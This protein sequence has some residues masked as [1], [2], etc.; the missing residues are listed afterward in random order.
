MSDEQ[1]IHLIHKYRSSTLSETEELAFFSWYAEVDPGEFHR[2]LQQAGE[3]DYE[4]ASPVF[5]SSL[6]ERLQHKEAVVRKMPILRRAAAAA[7]IIVLG[8]TAWY[9][10]KPDRRQVAPIIAAKVNDVQPGKSGAVLTLANGQVIALDS[11]G[12]GVIANQ[13][14]TT[15]TLNNGSLRYNA[16]NAA[17]VS[18]NMIRTPKARQFQLQLPDGTTVWLNAG[19]SLKYPTA[20]T[21][22]E[23]IVSITGEAFFDVAKD[24]AHPFVVEVADQVKVQVL[25]TQF[26]INAYPDEKQIRA[27]LLQGSIKVNKDAAAVV[28]QPGQQAQVNDEIT[29]NRN[30]NTSQ[31]SSWKDGVFNF[32]DLGVEA[33][34]RQLARW[35]DIEVVYEQGIP[36]NR[37]Y[38]E[39]GRNLSLAQ[40]LEGLKLSGVHFRI[41]GKRLI[42]LP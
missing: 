21:G 19:S 20:F 25:G 34:M 8:T 18:Y 17:A 30:I 22:K 12:N 15:V 31:V 7:A 26:N 27:T 2:I 14:G 28:L 11:A 32:D 3:V 1:I 9:V 29:V 4:P 24:A 42:V 16:D 41:E 5:L 39:I 36:T 10:F 38:G 13:N 33:V 6:E 35:Y 37:F 40:V 23:R